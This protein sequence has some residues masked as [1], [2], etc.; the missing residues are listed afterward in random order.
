MRDF[1]NAPLALQDLSD[2][3]RTLITLVLEILR[4]MLQT[5]GPRAFMDSL[6]ANALDFPGVVAIDEIEAH[7]HPTWQAL[8]GQWLQKCFPRV[9]FIITTHSPI[10]CRAMAVQGELRGSLW[11]LPERNSP[12]AFGRITGPELDRVLYGDL[13][14][15]LGTNIFGPHVE[16]SRDSTQMLSRLAELNVKALRSTLSQD[17]KLAQEALRRK[18]P[19][20]PT[21]LK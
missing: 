17:E 10:V 8:V 3:Y 12:Q 13:V 2:G 19:A 4:Q 14:E 6:E 11:K 20:R 18:F 15:A 1:T 7:L 16:Q 9:Q 5:A 21:I